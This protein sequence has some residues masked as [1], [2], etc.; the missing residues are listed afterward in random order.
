MIAR[1]SKRTWPIAVNQRRDRHHRIDGAEFRVAL[2]ALHQIDVDDL[3]GLDAF[4]IKGDAHA[5]GRQRAP[6][7]KQF[8]GIPPILRLRPDLC[9][10]F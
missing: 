9:R 1:D 8:H 7:R 4:E 10:L 3:V 2:L 6:E 5:V